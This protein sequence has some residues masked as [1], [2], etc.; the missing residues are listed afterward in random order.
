MFANTC[1]SNLLLLAVR[2]DAMGRALAKGWTETE[3][4]PA[5]DVLM[6]NSL[7]INM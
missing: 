5:E 4:K 3:G 7:H 1:G 2:Q 6:S